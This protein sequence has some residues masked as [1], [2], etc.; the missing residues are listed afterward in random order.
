[1]DFFRAWRE[2]KLRQV[3]ALPYVAGPE[4]VWI[5]LVT[6]RGSGRWILPKGWPKKKLP[7]P[8]LA[9]REAWEEA[10]LSG[11]IERVPIGH[12]VVRKRLHVFAAPRCRVDVYPLAVETQALTWPEQAQRKLMWFPASEAAETVSDKGVVPLLAELDRYL[13]IE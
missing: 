10:G 12:F 4:G 7:D 1:M 9:A 8:D 13:Q 6:S 11:Q 3:A 5:C 2:P